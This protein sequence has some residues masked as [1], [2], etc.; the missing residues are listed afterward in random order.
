MAMSNTGHVSN[1]P[2]LHALINKD[3]IKSK[4]S[5]HHSVQNLLSST[6]L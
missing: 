6:L 3:K 5:C 2:K 4:D 1:K